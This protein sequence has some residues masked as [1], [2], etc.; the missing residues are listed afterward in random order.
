M[1]VYNQKVKDHF[2]PWFVK[3][4]QEQE[5]KLWLYFLKLD[6]LVVAHNCKALVLV[7]C[8]FEFCRCR[9]WPWLTEIVSKIPH[10]F[11][12]PYSG[13][14]LHSELLSGFFLH[15]ELLVGSRLHHILCCPASEQNS[16]TYQGKH[17]HSSII[18]RSSGLSL[19]LLSIRLSV[20]QQPLYYLRD[21]MRLPHKVKKWCLNI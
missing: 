15:R 2:W 21:T 9:K 12:P 14:R 17:Y 4:S 1:T 5:K 20:I 3:I 11:T 8:C 6:L 18:T 13:R 10:S 7:C 19:V 16:R